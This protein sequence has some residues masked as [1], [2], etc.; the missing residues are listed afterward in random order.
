M[1]GIYATVNKKRNT[2][3]DEPQLDLS[4]PSTPLDAVQT[5][6]ASLQPLPSIYET[7]AFLAKEEEP[8][9]LTHQDVQEVS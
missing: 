5:D 6:G 7:P 2:E 9:V 4:L 1:T 8:L 3:Y